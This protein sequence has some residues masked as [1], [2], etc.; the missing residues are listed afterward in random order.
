MIGRIK[1]L[2]PK[3][4]QVLISRCCEYITLQGKRDFVDI[5]KL[6]N[7]RWGDSPGFSYVPNV[8][9]GVS[10]Y[11]CKSETGGNERELWL[12]K[13]SQRHDVV[14]FKM[15]EGV[16]ELRSM[17]ASRSEKKQREILP[18][19]S[20]K[21]TQPYQSFDLA[22]WDPGQTSNIKAKDSKFVLL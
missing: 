4:V 13:N 3:F 7:S 18:Y 9:A 17:M 12:Q 22:Q 1:L 16:Q 11:N 10:P 2:P 8:T 15:M 20:Q 14:G 6:R 5:I 19:R 21:G